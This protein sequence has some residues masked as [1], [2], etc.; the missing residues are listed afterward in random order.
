M[1]DNSPSPDSETPTSMPRW[2]K[3]VG[4]FVIVVLLVVTL[5]LAGIAD[6]GNCVRLSGDGLTIRDNCG[7]GDNSSGDHGGDNPSTGDRNTTSTGPDTSPGD[8]HGNR[9][10]TTAGEHHG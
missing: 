2:A 5:P 9:N 10:K 6:P 4:V 7:F 8:H 3:V 1:T